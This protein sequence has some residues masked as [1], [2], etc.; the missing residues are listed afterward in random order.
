MRNLSLLVLAIL[1]LLSC[2]TANEVVDV[3]E[4]RI[5]LKVF[6]LPP[7]PEGEGHYTLW[8]TFFS[9]SRR[10]GT[11]SPLH[12]EGF[13]NLGRFMV[14]PRD[15]FAYALDGGPAQFRIPDTLDAQLL[16]DIKIAIQPE[17]YH[18]LAKVLHEEEPGPG[19]VGGRFYGDATV[20]YADLTP[21]YTD[22]LGSNFST[23]RAYFSIM[24]PT[25]P[26]DS[27]SG[28]WFYNNGGP[29]LT[30]LPGLPEGW[31]Y[32]AWVR[33]DSGASWR[34]YST[35][36]FTRADTADADGAGP[37][38]GP[39]DGLNVPGQDFITGTPG[40]PNLRSSNYFF[41]V[42]VEPFPDNSPN[43]FFL[44]ILSN[45]P[46]VVEVHDQSFSL[47]ILDNVAPLSL[48][49]ARVTVLR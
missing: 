4:P 36:T 40:T 49:R 31:T 11:D 5:T 18:G 7:V 20:A 30:G 3:P 47:P 48:P 41:F 27:N 19:I 16:D 33:E 22:A 44:K 24:A 14:L 35:G 12:E 38:K 43:P 2:N 32:E 8:A 13:I 26:A 39:G 21:T 45:E 42:T 34:Y 9:F 1:P 25:S 15:S 6:N 46:V 37:G 28:M 17:D 23:A 29:G 10:A